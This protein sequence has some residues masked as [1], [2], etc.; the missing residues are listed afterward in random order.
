MLEA[1]HN[2]VLLSEFVSVIGA[3]SPV[4]SV[5]VHIFG[6]GFATFL[7]LQRVAVNTVFALGSS[8]AQLI[9]YA[10]AHA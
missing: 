2:L 6:C 8:T 5:S 7:C 1:K 9:D 3:F 10:F 4:T